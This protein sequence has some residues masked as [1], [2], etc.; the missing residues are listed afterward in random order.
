MTTLIEN[1]QLHNELNELFIISGKWLSEL[2]CFDKDLKT[3]QKLLDKIHYE[4]AG[5]RLSVLSE[6]D[7]FDELVL[8]R[9]KLMKEVS[10]HLQSI[11]P[12]L[13]DSSGPIHLS[14]IETHVKLENQM[15]NL[16]QSYSTFFKVLQYD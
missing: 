1:K 9:L 11:E 4:D 2:E 13:A 8:R 14:L 3:L 16:L 12:L 7:H 6:M 5:A 15:G 10:A